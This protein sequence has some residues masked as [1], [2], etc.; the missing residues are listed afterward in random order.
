MRVKSFSFKKKGESR[1]KSGAE[2]LFFKAGRM[3]KRRQT[4]VVLRRQKLEESVQKRER[5]EVSARGGE[6][7]SG[8]DA[9]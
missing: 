6:V 7:D 3:R 4:Y 1:K 9:A 8:V 2:N 5:E